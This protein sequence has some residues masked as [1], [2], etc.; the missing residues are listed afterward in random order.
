ML[1]ETSVYTLNTKGYSLASSDVGTW[2]DRAMSTGFGAAAPSLTN[3]DVAS[4]FRRLAG[5][6]KEQSRYLSNT[7]QM[8]ILWPYQNIIG[9]GSDAVPLILQE[10]EREPD[11]WFW[12]LEAITEE[13]PV[14]QSARG[15]V[16]LMAHAWIEW[17]KQRR[18]TGS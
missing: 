15:N 18:F 1:R 12:A 11:Q 5:Q 9:L 7:V 17:G 2:E 3:T 13:N 10:L 4:R 14:P 8:A 16:R 6:W